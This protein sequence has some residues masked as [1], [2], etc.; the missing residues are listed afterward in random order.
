MS[1]DLRI[2]VKVAGTD[3][4]AVI[5]RPEVDQPTYNLR[6]MF[7]ACMDWDYTQGEWYKVSE[8]YEKICRG[9]AELSGYPKKYKKYESDNGWGTVPEALEALISLRDCIDDIADP[10]GWRGWN[11]IPMKHLWVTW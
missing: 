7:V 11:T 10:N 3:I 6:D 1:Y 5:G 9:I 4:I 8:V 2:G